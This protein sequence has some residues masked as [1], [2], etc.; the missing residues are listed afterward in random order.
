MFG[1]NDVLTN[2][3]SISADGAALESDSA[4]VDVVDEDA[5]AGACV[6][7]CCVVGVVGVDGEVVDRGRRGVFA[8]GS[9]EGNAPAVGVA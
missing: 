1:S 9:C 3:C 6:G 8:A 5:V 7:G 4:F 2:P